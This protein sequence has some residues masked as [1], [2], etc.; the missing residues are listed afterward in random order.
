MTTIVGRKTTNQVRLDN[1][2]DNKYK[3]NTTKDKLIK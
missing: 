1:L 2:F 3:P